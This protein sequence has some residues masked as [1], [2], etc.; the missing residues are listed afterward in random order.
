MAVRIGNVYEKGG[1]VMKVVKWNL[2]KLLKGKYERIEH[3]VREKWT[4]VK[5][6]DTFS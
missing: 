3:I 4:I 2:K 6:V 5:P 1:S